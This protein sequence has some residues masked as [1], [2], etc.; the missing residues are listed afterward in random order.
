MSASAISGFGTTLQRGDGAA[1]ENFAAVAEL[2]D[3]SGVGAKMPTKAVTSSSDLANKAETKIPLGFVQYEQPKTK[4]NFIPNNASQKAI[5]NDVVTCTK[6]NYKIGWA[7]QTGDFLWGPF[8]CAAGFAIG[9]AMD[10][11]LGMEVTLEVLD[12]ATIP[13]T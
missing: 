2:R 12:K 6:R 5:L 13:T 4:F 8:S 10:E 3:I 11:E 1:P 7:G 9:T